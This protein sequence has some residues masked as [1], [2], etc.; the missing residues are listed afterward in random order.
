MCIRDRGNSDETVA[1]SISISRHRM[2][3][4]DTYSEIIFLKIYMIEEIKIQNFP[5]TRLNHQ[6][7]RNMR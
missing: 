6:K 3:G 1:I 7:G 5:K 2:I 4:M